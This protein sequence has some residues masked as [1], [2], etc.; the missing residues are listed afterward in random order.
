LGEANGDYQEILMGR[1]ECGLQVR[2]RR[3]ASQWPTSTWFRSAPS[4]NRELLL[5]D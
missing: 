1:Y 5:Q 4:G 2:G 3:K